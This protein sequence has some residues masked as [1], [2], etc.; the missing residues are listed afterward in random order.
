MS[1]ARSAELTL[2]LHKTTKTSTKWQQDHAVTAC[3]FKASSSRDI[4]ETSWDTTSTL[5]VNNYFPSGRRIAERMKNSHYQPISQPQV[6]CAVTGVFS[7]IP[8]DTRNSD[9]TNPVGLSNFLN[10]SQLSEA[11]RGFVLINYTLAGRSCQ[12][13]KQTMHTHYARCCERDVDEFLCLDS[14]AKCWNEHYGRERVR[15]R[16]GDRQTET[17]LGNH[18]AALRRS[19]PVVAVQESGR[20]AT[21]VRGSELLR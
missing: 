18:L 3:S 13:S 9:L 12:S 5:W 6:Q 4:S 15:F 1:L 17:G 10:L 8:D 2:P 16:E 14:A 11:Q 19:Y 20:S 21:S 7:C